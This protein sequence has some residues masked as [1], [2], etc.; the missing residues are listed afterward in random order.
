MARL[1]LKVKL[2]FLLL[3]IPKLDKELLQLIENIAPS[4]LLDDYLM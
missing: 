1:S 4:N 3:S 2:E